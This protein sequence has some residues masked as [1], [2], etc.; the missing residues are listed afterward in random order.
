MLS[1]DRHIIPRVFQTLSFGFGK[2]SAGLKEQLALI[3][4]YILLSS[5]PAANKVADSSSRQNLKHSA[6]LQHKFS[7]QSDIMGSCLTFAEHL[8]M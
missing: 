4:I 1:E 3:L 2:Q 7:K 8:L 6:P 5:L